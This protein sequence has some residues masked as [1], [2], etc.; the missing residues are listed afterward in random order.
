MNRTS[1]W[2]FLSAALGMLAV[3]TA[4]S[5]QGLKGE[6]KVDGSSTVFLITEA[7]ATNFKKQNP[8]INISVGVSGTGGGFK[9]FSAGETDISDASRKIRDAEKEACAKNNIEY[10]E[11]Q[12]AWDGLAVVIHPDNTWA[13]KMTVEHL[14]KIWHPDSAAKKWSD[15]DPNWPDQE[16]KLFGPGADSGTFDYFTEAINGK[17][18][19]SRKDYQASENDN[20]LVRGVAGNKY[21]MGYFGVAYFEENKDKLGIVAVAPAGKGLD[22]AVIPTKD[23]VLKG[24]YKPLSRPLFI[25]VKKDSLKRPE[26]AEFCK[27]YLRRHDLVSTAKYIE[28]PGRQQVAQ[29]EILEKALKASEK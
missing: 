15:V 3:T 14:K 23:T 7:M 22:A 10:V 13:R 6:I 4:A 12:V 20:D 27:F 18:K 26:V 24:I 19:L 2:T 25:Y 28:M 21:A 5:A 8:G 1:G 11:L 9:K 16:I 17:E 29:Q